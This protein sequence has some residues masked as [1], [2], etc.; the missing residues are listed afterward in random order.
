MAM[1]TADPVR[2]RGIH[3][4]RDHPRDAFEINVLLS[5]ASQSNE[6]VHIYLAKVHSIVRTMVLPPKD[7]LS[8]HSDTLNVAQRHVQCLRSECT[9]VLTSA[10][11]GDAFNNSDPSSSSFSAVIVHVGWDPTKC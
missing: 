11:R 8:G 2:P 9:R 6:L 10:S 7:T 4:T 3:R 5:L 1:G